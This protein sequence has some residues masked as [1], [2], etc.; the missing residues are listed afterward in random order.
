VVGC[1]IGYGGP[2]LAHRIEQ[3]LIHHDIAVLRV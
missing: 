3:Q 2:D 1:L